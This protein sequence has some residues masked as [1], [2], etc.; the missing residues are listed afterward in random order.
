LDHLK[1]EINS[2]S[3]NNSSNNNNN[4]NNNA[5]N[6]LGALRITDRAARGI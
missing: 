2:N 3:N 5:Q 6:I 4:N 1:Y